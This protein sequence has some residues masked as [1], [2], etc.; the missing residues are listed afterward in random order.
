MEKLLQ[1]VLQRSTSEQQLV[2]DLIPIKNPE[3]LSK[4]HEVRW[5]TSIAL[6]HNLCLKYFLLLSHD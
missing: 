4:T 6:S 5:L 2:V 1:V 3:K